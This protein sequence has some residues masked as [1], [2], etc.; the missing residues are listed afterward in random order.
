M[1]ND[2]SSN[3]P[4]WLVMPPSS[5]LLDSPT[6]S[7]NVEV[8][9]GARSRQGP[10]PSLKRDH[11]LI[12]RLG[13][14][15]ETLMTSLSAEDIPQR[16]DEW[17]YGMV[18]ADGMGSAGEAASRLAVSTLVHLTICFGKWNVRV[19][20]PI[21][22]EIMDRAEL[23]YR[24]V[25]STLLQATNNS[26]RDLQTG[27]T[28]VY[29]AGT[30]LFFAHVGRS[31]AYMF[32]DRELMQL[33]RDHARDRTRPG[34]AAIVDVEDR[35]KDPGRVAT[36]LLG[37]AAAGAPRIDIERCGVLDGDII[38]LCTSGLTSVADD[39]RIATALRSHGTPDDQCRALMDLASDAGGEDD[40]SALVAHYRIRE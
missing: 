9:F 32:R 40:A 15:H 21:A 27:L 39:A 31:R 34:S 28:A 3:V 23:F 20:E 37:G 29:T 24:S 7:V 6:P 33:T 13:R 30:E 14:H 11:Y 2:E 8:E 19:N 12:L 16:F 26:S 35:T 22:G 38:L 1:S 5:G 4:K 10:L 36:E 17:G 25:D 18:L